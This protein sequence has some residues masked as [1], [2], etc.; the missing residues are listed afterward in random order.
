ML[1]PKVGPPLPPR[2]RVPGTP[3]ENAKLE[4][5][6]RAR[7]AGMG[8]MAAARQAG[9]SGDRGN[10]TRLEQRE[11]VLDRIREISERLVAIAPGRCTFRQDA[12]MA[13]WGDEELNVRLFMQEAFY[14]LDI[15]RMFGHMAPATR[16]LELIGAIF[17]AYRTDTPAKIP[18]PHVKRKAQD[19]D[20]KLPPNTPKDPMKDTSPPDSVGS[21]LAETQNTEGGGNAQPSNGRATDLSEVAKIADLLGRGLGDPP[22]KRRTAAVPDGLGL[23]EVDG[24]E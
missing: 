24:D 13:G 6:A 8:Q 5:F 4:M 16:I 3:L 10:S 21:L 9:F 22:K 15:N 23:G 11:H 12:E 7:A 14:Q 1:K 17:C 2:P 20:G 18:L 19:S